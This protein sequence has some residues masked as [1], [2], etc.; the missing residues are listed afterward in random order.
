MREDHHPTRVALASIQRRLRENGHDGIFLEFRPDHGAG[1]EGC[2]RA[3][4]EA[5]EHANAG[6]PPESVW[7]QSLSASPTGWLVKLDSIGTWPQTQQWLAVFTAHLDNA[8]YPGELLAAAQVWLPSWLQANRVPRLTAHLAC[9]LSRPFV[10]GNADTR[11][12]AGWDVDSQTTAAVCAAAAAWAAPPGAPVLFSEGRSQSLLRGDD[13][14]AQLSSAVTRTAAAGIT[15]AQR[16]PLLVR[17]VQLAAWGQLTYQLE[18]PE[19]TW[20][21]RLDEL[22][23]V[24]VKHADLVE[25]AV[26]R[27]SPNWALDWTD[28]AGATP[29]LPYVSEGRV[30]NNRQLWAEHTPDAYGVQVLTE[31]HLARVNDLGGWEVSV[32]AP[33][34][35]LV[36]ARDLAPWYAATEPDA[37]VIEQAR[38][39]FGAAILTPEAIA[40]SS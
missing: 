22:R 29:P 11:G 4:A 6:V 36:Q 27:L 35:Y 14:E 20:H 16:S 1:T 9:R 24:L 38:R 7:A 12:R 26:I 19:Q 23:A 8:G 15:F 32:V 33:G 21:A 5:V 2:L 18:A 25:L 37:D 39:D 31:G 3:I 34:R 13:I 30:R 10:Q 17:R 40:A 28:L